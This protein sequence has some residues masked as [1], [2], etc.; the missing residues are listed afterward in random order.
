MEQKDS[1]VILTTSDL[2]KQFWDY[3]EITTS[4]YGPNYTVGPL[5]QTPRD[6]SA[7]LAT[8]GVLFVVG[9]LG[10]LV[11]LATLAK[12]R[13]RKSRVD[14]LMTHLAIADVCVTCGVIPLEVSYCCSRHA[15]EPNQ[16]IHF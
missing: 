7:V 12:T 1:T 6:Q 16:S 4:S 8:Y 10:N 14:L 9:A 3:F 2:E 13:R 5:D 11:V 15:A